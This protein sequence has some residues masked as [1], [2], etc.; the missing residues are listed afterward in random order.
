MDSSNITT[1]DIVEIPYIFIITQD[2]D[3]EV[4][5]ARMHVVTDPSP[6]HCPKQ[7]IQKYKAKT[8][9]NTMCIRHLKNKNTMTIFKYYVLDF[10]RLLKLY[11]SQVKTHFA[12]NV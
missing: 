9:I 8:S 6:H 3:D 4:P 12:L 7:I 2:M 1:P 10:T 5:F 11:V